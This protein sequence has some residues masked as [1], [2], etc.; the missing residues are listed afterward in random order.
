[1]KYLLSLITFMLLSSPLS[2]A[3]E[4]EQGLFKKDEGMGGFGGFS[5]NFTSDGSYSFIGE[6][7][8]RIHNFYIGGYG[9][10]T[11]LGTQQSSTSNYSYELRSGEGGLMLG[12]V[13]N[14]D[15]FF[16]LFTEVK[17]GWGSIS[18]KRQLGPNVYEEYE[19]KTQSIIP[20]IGIG[21]S[22]VSFIQV[23]IYAAYH[24]SGKIEL[25]GIDSALLN[26][27]NFGIGIYFGSF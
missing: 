12:A 25:D 10:S 19:E 20:K 3:Q 15:Q 21:L 18:A 2:H 14:T 17:I 4:K 7:A 16:S 27:Y 22:P 23:R 11:D 6:G 1:M 26:D 8:A 9:Y 13:S 5:F 24:F